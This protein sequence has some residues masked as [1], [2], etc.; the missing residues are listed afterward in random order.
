[1]NYREIGAL[2]HR[3]ID[4]PD[5]FTVPALKLLAAQLGVALPKSLLRRKRHFI[6]AI[7]DEIGRPFDR[8]ARD[9]LRVEPVLLIEQ[10][11]MNRALR[12]HSWSTRTVSKFQKI[13]VS[14]TIPRAYR[15]PPTMEP[16]TAKQIR[17]ARASLAR[18]AA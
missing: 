1:M 17:E 10:T 14:R 3:L 8:E 4:E 5:T 15:R 11:G 7:L 6:D 12:R 13:T 9:A 2:R 18:S 16:A